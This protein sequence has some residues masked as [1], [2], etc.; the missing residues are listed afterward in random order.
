M[1]NGLCVEISFGFESFGEIAP[2]PSTS[3]S[4]SLSFSSN[5]AN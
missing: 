2:N 3:F 4:P 1:V 5:G